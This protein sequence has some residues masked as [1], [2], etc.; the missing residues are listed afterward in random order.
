MHRATIIDQATSNEALRVVVTQRVLNSPSARADVSTRTRQ[1]PTP[2]AMHT[3]V[4]SVRPP[5]PQG[6]LPRST[7]VRHGRSAALRCRPVVETRAGIEL[8]GT[9]GSRSPL[10]NWYLHELGCEFEMRAPRDPS[11]PH[12]FGQV[13][14]LRDNDT[15]VFESGA[16]LAYIADAYGGVDTPQKRAQIFPWLVWANS[17]LDP[18]LFVETPEGRVVDTGA[19]GA[20]GQVRALDRL[21]A[22]LSEKEWLV[23]GEFSAADVAV[24]AYLLYVP[25]FFRDIN[26]GKWPAVSQYMLRC[27]SR[28]GYAAA[29]SQEAPYL[30]AKCKEFI[31][32]GATAESPLKRFKL[33]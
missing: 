28:E 3:S 6:R 9:Q 26:M 2:A 29:Y 12:P 18:C 20:A 15:E 16:I 4:A 24:G 27:A 8:Y 10:V 17:T 7:I 1:L 21:E 11:N 31:E 30:Q 13:P 22:I 19:R 5:T 32:K 14:A 23:G 25:Q 33:F